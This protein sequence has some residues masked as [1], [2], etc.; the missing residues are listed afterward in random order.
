M[1]G[2]VYMPAIIGPVSVVNLDGGVMQFGD[3]LVISPKNAS[4]TITGSGSSNAGALIF[5]A[6]GLS[7]NNVLDVDGVD[8]PLSGNN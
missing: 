6:S 5:N 8:Q 3:T 2:R 7:G 4:K 1:K